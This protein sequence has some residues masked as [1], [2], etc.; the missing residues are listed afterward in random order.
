MQDKPKIEQLIA[1]L[2]KLGQTKGINTVFTTFL[3][4]SAVCLDAQF[5]PNLQAREQQELKY[6]AMAAKLSP[7]ELSAYARMLALLCLEIHAHREEPCDILGSIYHKLNLNNEWNGQFFTP[8]YLCR[9]M[10]EITDHSDSE[11]LAQNGYV[12]ICD[13]ACGS[14]AMFLASVWVMNR[15]KV[16]FQTSCLFVGRDID[17]RCVWMA[18]IQLCLYRVPAVIIHGNSLTM[19]EWSIWQTPYAHLPLMAAKQKPEQLSEMASA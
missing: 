15:K 9:M 16:D 12:T 8:D 3:E 14:G 4:I 6:A 2:E 1:E 18:Y 7:E 11:E 10:A 17:I 19:E 13:P 5:N